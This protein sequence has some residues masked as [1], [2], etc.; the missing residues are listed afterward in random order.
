[1]TGRLTA[2]LA[3]VGALG[4]AFTG[5]GTGAS[6]VQALGW[7]AAAGVGLSAMLRGPGLRVMGALGVLLAVASLASAALAGGWAWL[8]VVFSL[9]LGAAGAA[10]FRRG[11]HWR[12][13]STS[14]R[15]EPVRDLWKQFDAGDDP[16][17]DG[18]EPDDH[19][20]R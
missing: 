12:A 14:T 10:A 7:A 13:G 6:A 1:M 15:R 16:T 20:P 2:L 8:A 9:A 19:D 3:V 11:P 18:E 4:V 17:T 5:L